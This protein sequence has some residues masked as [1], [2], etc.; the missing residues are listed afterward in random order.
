LP[1]AAGLMELQHVMQGE[2]I[3]LHD[4]ET[5]VIDAALEPLDLLPA[6][7]AAAALGAKRVNTCADKFP[8]LVQTFA[9]IC[10]L[11]EERE[12]GVDIECMAWR[13][14]DSPHACLGLIE[15]SGAANAAYLVD[16]LHHT[17][18]GGTAQE[19]ADE[20]ANHI[21]SAQ[22]CDA[23]AARPIGHEALIAEA[24]GGRLIPGQGDLPLIEILTALPDHTVFSVELP[25]A[26]DRRPP[27]D[28]AREIH[29]ATMALLHS[30]T[31]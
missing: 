6:F 25:C 15:Q 2:G 28:R 29:M 26:A 12:L 10:Q 3:G 20:F 23:P 27:H 13:G 1:D 31:S 24:R 8:G 19:L 21:V 17:R 11:A 22:L 16:A 9:H 30:A 14:I 18:C 7:D 5:I 4:I